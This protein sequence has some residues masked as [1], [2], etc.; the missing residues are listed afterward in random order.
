MKTKRNIKEIMLKPATLA[1]GAFAITTLSL[2]G[3][4][5]V[6]TSNMLTRIPCFYLLGQPEMPSELMQMIKESE[7]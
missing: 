4:A 1:F 6:G 5:A 3:E 2:L 7:V